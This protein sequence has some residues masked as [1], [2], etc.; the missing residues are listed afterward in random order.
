MAV[1]RTSSPSS[2]LTRIFHRILVF[3]SRQMA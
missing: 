1:G 3:F 2:A